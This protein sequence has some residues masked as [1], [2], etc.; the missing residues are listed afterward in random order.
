MSRLSPADLGRYP[1]FRRPACIPFARFESRLPKHSVLRRL[2]KQQKFLDPVPDRAALFGSTTQ[3][4]PKK[5]C[6]EWCRHFAFHTWIGFYLVSC[7]SG[8]L[9]PPC[10]QFYKLSTTGTLRA[11]PPPL[12]NGQTNECRLDDWRG[13]AAFPPAFYKIT[14]NS[15][16]FDGCLFF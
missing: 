11:A 5:E 4:L 13:D 9:L 2:T 7:I 14:K 16:H 1:L 12:I 10:G 8:Y 15:V 3:G 6:N